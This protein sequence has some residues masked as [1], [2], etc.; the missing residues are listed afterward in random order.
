MV[1]RSV[2]VLLEHTRCDR[3]AGHLWIVVP[4]LI[5]AD[6]EVGLLLDRGVA[7]ALACHTDDRRGEARHGS[8]QTQE[9][10]PSDDHEPHAYHIVGAT[11]HDDTRD[12]VGCKLCRCQGRIGHACGDALNLFIH[13][14]RGDRV[15]KAWQHD[16]QGSRQLRQI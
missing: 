4:I 14:G 15:N 3:L 8:E 6:A 11:V 16:P 2:V 13:L 1:L 10:Q 12:I 9:A 5:I 7:D